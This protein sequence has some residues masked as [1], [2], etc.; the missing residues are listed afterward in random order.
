MHIYV[1]RK[2]RLQ[3]SLD[4]SNPISLGSNSRETYQMQNT[5]GSCF[6]EKIEQQEIGCTDLQ[7]IQGISAI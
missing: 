7:L 1:E 2:S 3:H 4:S 5:S 6:K